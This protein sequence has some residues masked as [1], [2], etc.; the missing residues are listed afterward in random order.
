MRKIFI[1]KKEDDQLIA[2]RIRQELAPYLGDNVEIKMSQD[3]PAG[4]PWKDWIIEEL[5]QTDL[6]LLLITDMDKSLEWCLYEAGLFTPISDREPRPTVCIYPAGKKTPTQI[7]DVQGVECTVDQIKAF[8]GSLFDGTLLGKPINTVV[9]EDENKLLEISEKLVE[10]LTPDNLSK[11]DRVYYTRYVSFKIN[12]PEEDAK[13]IPPE[14]EVTGDDLSLE[15]FQ[16]DRTR[17][18]GKAWTWDLFKPYLEKTLKEAGSDP[19]LF[20]DDFQQ[21][22]LASCRGEKIS[23]S[24]FYVRSLTSEKKYQPVIHRRDFLGN[25]SFRIRV[26]FIQVSEPDTGERNYTFAAAPGE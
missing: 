4:E 5:R 21:S 13:N 10:Y 9:A 16:L 25:N 20:F 26:L 19:E 7:E 8:L 14:C 23:P 1:S 12:L 6:F 15:L 17:P 24:Q 11:T 2:K 22:V 3:I 18:G